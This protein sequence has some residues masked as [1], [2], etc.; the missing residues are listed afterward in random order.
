MATLAEQWDVDVP[1]K[2][3]KVPPAVQAER[4][5][6]RR[7]I[8]EDEL[9]AAKK[10]FAGGDAQAQTEVDSLTSELGKLAPDRKSTR[11]NSSH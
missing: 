5:V 3:W 10:R 6:T 8:I 2:N 9:G 4:D 1:S 11:L 7:Q